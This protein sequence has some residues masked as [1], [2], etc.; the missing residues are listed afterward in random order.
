[1]AS[2]LCGEG[3]MMEPEAIFNEIRRHFRT[4]QLF[5]DKKILISAGPTYE[6][7]DPVRYIGNH[8][9]GKMGVEMAKAFANAG[10]SVKLVLGPTSLRVD[11]PLIEVFPVTSALQMYEACLAFSAEADIL[12]MS[13]AV[14]DYRPEKMEETKIK[15]SVESIDLKLVKN[16]DI[17]K[18]LGELKNENQ[19]LAGFALETDNEL[20][21]AWHKL[22]TKKADLIVLNSLADEGAGFGTDTN[23]VICITKDGTQRNFE[24]Q[25]KRELAHNLIQYIYELTG[26]KQANA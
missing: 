18:K 3:R 26:K 25:S 12:V 15:K 1:L 10:A 13:A 7:I 14:A 11:Y 19:F 23:K 24:L 9:T 6:A 16:P 17:L 8:S 2:G 4:K 20:E 22:N 21:N 5:R